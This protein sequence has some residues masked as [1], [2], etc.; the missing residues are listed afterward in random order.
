MPQITLL[1]P[2]KTLI[3]PSQPPK[4]SLDVPAL[5]IFLISV[6]SHVQYLDIAR[7]LSVPTQNYSFNRYRIYVDMLTGE[8]LSSI[9][10]PYFDLIYWSVR[11]SS[12]RRGNVVKG[13]W[14][15]S[16][17]NL[18]RREYYFIRVHANLV[19]HPSNNISIIPSS[20]LLCNSIPD[21]H[22]SYIMGQGIVNYIGF[23]RDVQAFYFRWGGGV[24]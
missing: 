1:K 7:Y 18:A 17:D 14:M 5:Y 8:N 6:Y 16:I 3:L 2:M 11:S 20:L 15:R 10:R 22:H 13:D 4:K 24:I 12:K 21:Q 9:Y 19:Q 23:I